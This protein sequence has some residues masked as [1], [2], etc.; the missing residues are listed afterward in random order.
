MSRSEKIKLHCNACLGQRWHTTLYLTKKLHQEGD[1]EDNLIYEEK[2]T[3]R[4][5]ECNGCE[6]ISLHMDWWCSGLDDTEKS[7]WPPKVSRRQPKWMHELLF[8]E[9]IDNPFK[10]DFLQEIYVSLEANNLRLAVLGIRALLEQI[11]IESVEDQ[12]SFVANLSKFETDGFISKLQ[13]EALEPVIEAGHASMHRGFKASAAEVEAIMDVIENLIESIY[14][15]KK[16]SAKLKIPP[17]PAKK[18]K[19]ASAIKQ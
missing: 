5:V 4:L 2:C 8:S 17:R 19:K 10:R 9:S 11:M 12:G 16:K 14:I 15:S 6:N 3:Y 13:R 1:E 7:Q 18:E